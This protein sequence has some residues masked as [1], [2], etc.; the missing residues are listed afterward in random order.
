MGLQKYLRVATRRSTAVSRAFALQLQNFGHRHRTDDLYRMGFDPVLSAYELE[1]ASIARPAPHEVLQAQAEVRSA[2]ALQDTH[3]FRS[4]GLEL[5]EHLHIESVEPP[6]APQYVNT[7]IH[8]VRACA[9]RHFA[10]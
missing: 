10:G 6:L 4:S 9:Q 2:D 5:L 1:P 8:R 7:C 3:V